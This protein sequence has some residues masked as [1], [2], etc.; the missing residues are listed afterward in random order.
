MVMG[1]VLQ[2]PL[3]L[4]GKTVEGTRIGTATFGSSM[5]VQPL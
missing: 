4:A 5:Q 1:F 3:S 2:F